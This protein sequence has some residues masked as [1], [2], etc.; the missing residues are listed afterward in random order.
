MLRLAAAAAAGDAALR[1]AVVR[2]D[3]MRSSHRGS[4]TSTGSGGGGGGSGKGELPA[5]LAALDGMALPQ[6]FLATAVRTVAT[7]AMEDARGSRL[8][9]GASRTG[10]FGSFPRGCD[11]SFGG[12][13]SENDGSD[14]SY[15]SG[16]SD[17]DSGDGDEDGMESEDDD[18]GNDWYGMGANCYGGF[19][20][21]GG[22]KPANLDGVL[23]AAGIG[24]DMNSIMGR[25]LAAANGGGHSSGDGGGG[26]FVEVND[27]DAMDRVMDEAGFWGG[28]GGGSGGGG[29][30][31]GFVSDCGGNG[32][33]LLLS[34]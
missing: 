16:S 27:S 15:D 8:G 12:G 4:G 13:G 33:L 10:H 9:S 30:Y 26:D 7:L 18:D 28:H 34:D 14:E 1:A 23:Q 6:A 25:I 17:A 11:G 20:G 32:G 22:G 19:G 29:G 2:R 5:A 3:L 31:D 24:T 21:G